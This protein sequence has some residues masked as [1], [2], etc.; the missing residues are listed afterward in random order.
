MELVQSGFTLLQWSSESLVNAYDY[1]LIT[2]ELV[3]KYLRRNRRMFRRR[4]FYL[5]SL[6]RQL[7]LQNMWQMRASRVSSTTRRTRRN[8]AAA[9][10]SN[11][12]R[13][14]T[15]MPNAT[16]RTGRGFVLDTAPAPPA[17]ASGAKLQSLE[18][19]L[20]KLRA[21]IAGLMAE[22][23][24]APTKAAMHT[25][26]P[27]LVEAA[28][29]QQPAPIQPMP[30]EPTPMIAKSI[31]APPPMPTKNAATKIA[32]SASIKVQS[33][34]KENAVGNKTTKTTTFKQPLAISKPSANEFALGRKSLRRASVRRSI[35]GTP[36]RTPPK[37]R[38]A[39]R[40]DALDDQSAIGATDTQALIARALRK[41]FAGLKSLPRNS[42]TP[43]NTPSGAVFAGRGRQPFI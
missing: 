1:L 19:E 28:P 25:D 6:V 16:A 31:P 32:K 9:N 8:R 3:A 37:E 11:R 23:S 30:V 33:T 27:K 39:K 18:D 14:R 42:P 22:G 35:G 7:G 5:R 15:I 4:R 40:L 34:N 10:G 36:W 41:K 38:E 17:P 29:T 13:R 20:S 24:S 21:E 43:N 26:A 2:P 12:A